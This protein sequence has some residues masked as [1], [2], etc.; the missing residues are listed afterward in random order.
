MHARFLVIGAGLSGLAA[1]IRLARFNDDVLLLEKH[2]RAGGLNSY[3]Y[4]NNHL[5]ETGLHAITNFAPK[6]LKKAPLNRLLRQLKIRREE[7]GLLQQIKSEVHFPSG[8]SLVF[9]NDFEL[10]RSEID[11]KFPSSS[12]G[13]SRLVSYLDGSDPF[14]PGPYVSA[15]QVLKRYIPD[16][17]LIDMILCPLLFYGSSWEDDID[18]SQFVIMFRS[19][20]QEGMFRPQ[21]SIK[22]FLDLLLEKLE[23]FGGTIRMRT[24][25]K[26]ITHKNR[27]VHSVILDNDEEI[28]CDFLVSTIGSE[29]TAVKLGHRSPETK[30]NRLGFIE[31]IFQLPGS[32][33]KRLPQDRTCIFYNSGNRFSFR[34]PADSVDLSSGVICLP[35]NFEGSEKSRDFIEVRTTHLANFD[36]WH[37]VSSDQNKYERLKE[38]IA[39]RS[40]GIAEQIIGT[41]T[42][43]ITFQDTF[44]P[45]TIQRYT[46]KIEGAIYG[47]PNKIKDGRTEYEN[48]FIA[49]TDQG[50]LG[51]VGSMLS[52]VTIV[53]QHILSRL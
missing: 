41:F 20:F 4:R 49:G 43:Q 44:T 9:S 22:E 30:L 53:N 5:F 46:G 38:E 23:L 7:I 35:F 42:D 25:V 19:I 14:L 39:V 29:E 37:N 52:G 1:A 8:Q 24:P 15:R 12:D 33:R 18:F 34:K 36:I 28:T 17:N 11:S 32:M 2:S 51:I 31:N 13:F 47:S 45:V 40:S 16:Q 3:Y 6:S 27:K 48:L 50:F 26:R 10:L 21:G